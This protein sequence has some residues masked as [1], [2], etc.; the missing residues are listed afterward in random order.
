MKNKFSGS[1][2]DDFLQEEGLEAEVAARAAKK[3]FSHQLEEQMKRKRK[4]RTVLRT[5]LGS[6]TTTARLF[7]EHTGISLLTMARAADVVE[8]DIEVRL[9]ERT[10]A[11]SKKRR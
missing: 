5:A 10:T 11:S 9:V 4:Q 3:T 2:F 1:S 7:N 6:P 8:C